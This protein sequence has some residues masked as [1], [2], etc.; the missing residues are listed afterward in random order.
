LEGIA[1]V[2]VREAELHIIREIRKETEKRL[3]QRAVELYRDDIEKI[4]IEE[5]QQKREAVL[6][7]VK[8]DLDKWIN[9]E[10]EDEEDY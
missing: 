3:K 9:P 4:V 5:L 6:E 7:A 1:R 2:A 10:N 8:N